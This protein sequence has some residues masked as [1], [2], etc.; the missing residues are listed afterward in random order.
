MQEHFRRIIDY[1]NSDGIRQKCFKVAVDA[2]NGV[3]AIHTASFL[4]DHLG[5]E[6]V[7]IFD[8]TDGTF[9]RDPEPSRA[10]LKSLCQTVME[11]R[12]DLG[13]AQDPDGDRLAL[14]DEHGQAIGEDLTL[15]IAIEQ[16]LARHQQTPVVINLSTSKSV[17]SVAQRQGSQV[18]RTKIGEIYVTEAMLDQGAAVG[19][20]GNG[21]VVIPDIHPCRDSYTGMAIVLEHLLDTGQSLSKC[22]AN[23]P[24]YTMVKDKKAI[25]EDKVKA[26]LEAINT[27]YAAH[28]PTTLDGIY[29]DFGESWLHVRP[30]NTEPVLRVTVEVPTGEKAE[31]LLQELNRIIDR[32]L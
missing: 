10:N 19:G 23:I 24:A 5:C 12:C 3:G 14:V 31:P 30:S 11:H 18:N 20:E 8:R 17:A 13:F 21:G 7:T 9:E 26:I 28:H 4:R 27:H 16:V 25:P 6:V 32:V 29:V 1:V 22:C 15:A 2:C